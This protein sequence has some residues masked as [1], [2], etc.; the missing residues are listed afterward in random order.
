MFEQDSALAHRVRKMV[1]FLDRK[2]LD[3]MSSCCLVLTW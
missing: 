2:S 3:F 1:A